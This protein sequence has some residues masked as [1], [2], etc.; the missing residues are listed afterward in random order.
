MRTQNITRDVIDQARN[1][2]ERRDPFT[3]PAWR[4][5]YFVSMLEDHDPMADP[6]MRKLAGLYLAGLDTVNLLENQPDELR[7]IEQ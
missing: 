4:A 5:Y 7:G 6:K 3:A 1:A 2:L